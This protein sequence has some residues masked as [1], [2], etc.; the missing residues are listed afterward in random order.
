MNTL[1]ARLVA[2]LMAFERVITGASVWCGC[3][4]MA[5][6]AC[7][8]LYQVLT[9]FILNE[10]AT[11]SEPFIRVSLIWMAYL[12][13]AGAIR[14]GALVSVDFLYRMSRGRWRRA[15]EGAVS[16]ATLCL[17]G[18]LFWFGSDLA[19]RVRFQNLAGLEIPI[20]YAYA[21]IP[22]GSLIS[23]LSVVAHYFDPRR[24]ELETAV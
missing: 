6:A 16:L 5:A 12:G 23:M 18:L 2:G 21:A 10:P 22:V 4:M 15:L 14:A 19:Y 1:T 8:G 24:D 17:L 11:W 3:A 13:L 7:V 20:S 9:R